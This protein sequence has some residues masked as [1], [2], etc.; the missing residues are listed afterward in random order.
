M[1]DQE[2][3]PPPKC[4][5]CGKRDAHPIYRGRCEDCFVDGLGETVLRAGK[6]KTIGSRQD[7]TQRGVHDH[8]AYAR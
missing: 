2:D 5:S 6:P 3:G 7:A 1:K 8:S 4:S